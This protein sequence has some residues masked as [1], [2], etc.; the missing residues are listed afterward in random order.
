MPP[1]PVPKTT[2]EQIAATK[3]SLFMPL[4]TSPRPAL[5]DKVLAHTCRY[6][7]CQCKKQLSYAEAMEKVRVGEADW[8]TIIPLIGSPYQVHNAIELKVGRKV[9]RISDGSSLGSSSTER[10]AEIGLKRR[11]EGAE[12]LKLLPSVNERGRPVARRD[13]LEHALVTWPELN[14]IPFD[15]DELGIWTNTVVCVGLDDFNELA[16]SYVMSLSEI[17][18]I[19]KSAEA[20]ITARYNECRVTKRGI[21]ANWTN[22]PKDFRELPVAKIESALRRYRI[23]SATDEFQR[24]NFEVRSA[25][26]AWINARQNYRD[27]STTSDIP[28]TTLKRRVKKGLATLNQIASSTV[29]K[30]KQFAALSE[31]IF[32]DNGAN[33]LDDNAQNNTIISTGGSEI[34]GRIISGKKRKV[35]GRLVTEQLDTFERGF[36]IRSTRGDAQSDGET[37]NRQIEFD[38]HGDESNA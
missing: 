35:D 38:D 20:K 26:T 9:G 12:D 4:D 30:S 32:T 33:I 3:A 15:G 21:F 8:W 27:A 10:N 13:E 29:P 17:D 18:N 16:S 28:E 5:S 2:E 37:A 23:L 6:G 31:E 34:G 24:L 1:S 25:I 22:L 11:K 36:N 19:F 14:E 7:K